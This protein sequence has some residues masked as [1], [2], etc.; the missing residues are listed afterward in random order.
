[1]SENNENFLSLV[2]VARTA[3]VVTGG[4]RFS[5]AAIVV[6]GNKNG[7]V[8]MG[9]GKASEVLEAN[10][11]A[12]NEAKKSMIRIPLKE[13]RTIHHDVVGKFGSGLVKM[14]SAPPG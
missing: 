6:A 11:K 2:H 1:M 14:R 13:G 12:E 5:F 8:G 9:T 7:M 3:K 4:R 10:K